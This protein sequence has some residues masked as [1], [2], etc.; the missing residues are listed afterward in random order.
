MGA[1]AFFFFFFNKIYNNPFVEKAF[2]IICGDKLISDGYCDMNIYI[3]GK[4]SNEE[5]IQQE[6]KKIGSPFEKLYSD[7]YSKVEEV[8]KSLN[9]FFN[10]LTMQ[11]YQKADEMKLAEAQALMNYIYK[12][13]KNDEERK[14]VTDEL[15]QFL[16]DKYQLPGEIKILEGIAYLNSKVKLNFIHSIDK[17]L[18]YIKKMSSSGRTIFY[19]GHAEVNYILIPSVMRRYSLLINERKMYNEL[20]IKCP[21]N[22]EKM[23]SHLEYLVEMQHYGLPTRLL[24]ITSNPLVAL[25]FA[26]ENQLDSFGEIV[27]FSV[28]DCDIK[29]PHS[30]TVSILASLPMF[31]YEKQQEIYKY[32]VDID[33]IQ[34]EF[35]EKVQRLLHEVKTEKPAF[36]DEIVKSDMIRSRVVLSLK[37]NNRIIKQDGAFILCGLSE[38][39]RHLDVNKLRYKESNDKCEIFI[40]KD[41]EKFLDVLNAFSINKATLFPEIDDVADYIK[42]KY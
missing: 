36:K 23:K 16:K 4:I 11:N 13:L 35:N 28:S 15:M 18:E 12:P 2:Y 32:A 33:L 21:T 9:E 22:F 8:E 7:K 30:D 10:F 31:E 17:F 5:S 39:Y 3:S 37:N 38:D 20:L 34:K 19:R 14:K 42:S 40:I 26:C 29:Y 27:V 25:Y 1:I 41:K 6:L 24:D